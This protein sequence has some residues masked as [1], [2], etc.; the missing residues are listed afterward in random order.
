MGTAIAT[1]KANIPFAAEAELDQRASERTI[2]DLHAA[3]LLSDAARNEALT[4]LCPAHHWW[5]WANRALLFVGAALTLAGVVFFFAYNWSRMPAVAKFS[6]IEVGLWVCAIGAIRRGLN[7]LSGKVLLLAACVF[8]GVL[9][10][11]YGQTYQTGADAFENYALWALLILPWVM[12]GKFGALWVLWLVVT[13]VALILFWI[14]FEPLERFDGVFLL[15]PLLAGMNALA[16]IGYEYGLAQRW[17]WLEGR[18]IRHLV[19]LSVLVYLSIPT[20]AFIVEPEFDNGSMLGLLVMMVALPAGFWYF[21]HRAADLP[22]LAFTV[23]AASTAIL[24]FIGKVLF[25][26]SEG[27]PAFFLF[28]LIVLGLSSAAAFYLRHLNKE[29]R[30]VVSA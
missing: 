25:E 2:F 1:E 21:R 17:T 6:I 18:W 22:C 26:I 27:A 30:H 15:F 19:W 11:V 20:I 28:G 5:C 3:G 23:M 13:N 7:R 14:Q 4:V 10:A 24:T 29:M 9:F 12:L 16:L 8:V